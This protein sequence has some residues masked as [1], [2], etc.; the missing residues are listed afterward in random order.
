MTEAFKIGIITI[1]NMAEEPGFDFLREKW[2]MKA[3]HEYSESAELKS[4]IFEE[5]ERG[6]YGNEKLEKL[7]KELKEKILRYSISAD[8]LSMIKVEN[9]H[10]RDDVQA[11]DQA[12][13][14]AHNA[15][16]DQLNIL[17]RAFKEDGLSNEWRRKVGLER[18]EVGEWAFGVADYLRAKTKEE[19]Q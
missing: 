16:I 10:G 7:F 1:S 2:K 12:R 5:I 11:A 8:R 15:V 3:E 19:L 14:L 6:A 18:G 17:S 4:P 13:R 9:G